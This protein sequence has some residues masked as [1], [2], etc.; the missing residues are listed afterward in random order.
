[1]MQC[2]NIKSKHY[3]R[4]R[5]PNIAHKGEFCSK[6]SKNP[7]RFNSDPKAQ[8]IQRVWKKFCLK[9]I[10]SRHGP[11]FFDKTLA[12]NQTELYSL[13]SLD[14][15]PKLYFFS[16]SD[17]Q[18]NIWAF[19]IRS[20]SF[21]LSK[22]NSIKNPYTNLLL[23]EPIVNKIKSRISWLKSHKC[24][25]I[26]NHGTN[27][28]NEQIWNQNVLDVFSEIEKSGYL[29]NTDWFHALDKEDHI[30]FY[31]SLYDIWNYRVGLNSK[32]KSLIVPTYNRK[33]L[34][35]YPSE[36]LEKE[37]KVLKK[38]NLSNIKLLVN[39]NQGIIYVL[40]AFCM[41]NSDVGDAYPWIRDSI[42]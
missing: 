3:S 34:K 33:L 20:L 4:L 32:E 14:S 18:K 5:C 23:S 26:H 30:E 12:N 10:F 29:V 39:S 8:L 28:T 19:D 24:Q 11:A 36:I 37:E 38:I 22:S 6:H 9:K 31:K 25:V 21:L 7:I 40:M 35:H 13:E 42:S 2:V 1:M 41:V 15:I 27:F 17:E 16:F